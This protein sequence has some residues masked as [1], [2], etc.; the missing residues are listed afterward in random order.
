MEGNRGKLGLIGFYD[1][2][3]GFCMLNVKVLVVLYG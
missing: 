1:N 3:E 2:F